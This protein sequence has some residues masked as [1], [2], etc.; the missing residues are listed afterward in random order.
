MGP[1][2]SA[3]TPSAVPT[4]SNGQG[5]GEGERGGSSPI[6]PPSLDGVLQIIA[7]ADGPIKDAADARRLRRKTQ[8][9][10]IK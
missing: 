8:F 5:E 3:G 10:D 7:D 9:I 4:G 6:P 1:E 2:Y